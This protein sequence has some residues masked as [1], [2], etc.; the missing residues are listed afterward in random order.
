MSQ[1]EAKCESLRNVLKNLY[2]PIEQSNS[3][4]QRCYFQAPVDH[5]NDG[6]TT[7][8]F[9]LETCLKALTTEDKPQVNF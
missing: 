1:V 6:Q 2:D 9:H 5:E 3:K 8:H 4:N 7:N